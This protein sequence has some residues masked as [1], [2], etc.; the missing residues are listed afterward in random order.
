MRR[1]RLDL[2][3]KTGNLVD[4]RVGFSVI[5]RWERL[6]IRR[7]LSLLLY[8]FLKRSKEARSNRIYVESNH[9]RRRIIWMEY[10]TQRMF[11]RRSKATS[12]KTGN[13]HMELSRRCSR[14]CIPA[15]GYTSVS[16]WPLWKLDYGL[17]WKS[18][19]SLVLV[20]SDLK[21]SWWMNDIEM[22]RYVFHLGR[23]RASHKAIRKIGKKKLLYWNGQRKMKL[24]RP[25]VHCWYLK[26]T[27]LCGLDSWRDQGWYWC[28][29]AIPPR[30]LHADL[31]LP[32]Y[33]PILAYFAFGWFW[34]F[35]FLKAR[36]TEISSF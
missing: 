12:Y 2:R 32:R 1:T 6:C 8:V 22:P 34:I 16:S 27:C 29:S 5:H 9:L 3:I 36:D 28:S 14:S 13:G 33:I 7:S 26:V 31:I 23:H 25:G 17:K 18:S 4:L 30:G 19:D 35:D 20:F 10:A 21:C 11:Q 24:W 15:S